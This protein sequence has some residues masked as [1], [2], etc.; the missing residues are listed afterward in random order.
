MRRREFISL[1]GGAAVVWPLAVRAALASEASGQRGDSK[2]QQPAMPV[3]GYLGAESPERMT[4]RLRAFLQGLGTTGY[5]EGRNVAIEYRWAQGR[6]DRLPALAADLVS[7]EVSVIAAPGSLASALAAKAA[8]ST[9]PVVFETGAD[10]VEA[11]LV[12]SLNRPAGNL[13]GVTS[14][15]AEVGPKRLQ[16]LHELLPATTAFALLVNPTNPRNAEASTR[17]LQAAA[18][19]RRLELHVLRASTERELEEVFVTLARQQRAGGL[20]IANETFFANRGEQLAA[21]ALRHAIPA[22]HQRE[23]AAAGGLIGY[24]GDVTHSHGQAGAYVGRILKGEKPA[25]LPV[26]QV[27]AVQLIINLRTAKALGLE[28][29]LSLIARADE[30][31]E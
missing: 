12:S 20:V 3:V 2:V 24:G 11:G 19:A 5:V 17:D 7:R 21:L 27:T 9:I 13:T 22:V 26:Q 25:D 23:F 31:I 10:P 6:N 15:N 16:L 1:L 29:P 4:L 14:L 18:R 28:V 30:V 8:T